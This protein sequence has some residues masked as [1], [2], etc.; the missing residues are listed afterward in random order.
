MARR[1]L[2]LPFGFAGGEY[3]WTRCSLQVLMLLRLLSLGL[4]A[5]G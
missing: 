1:L 2:R 3:I 5:L 4:Y